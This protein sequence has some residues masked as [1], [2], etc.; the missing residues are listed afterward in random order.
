MSGSDMGSHMENSAKSRKLKEYYARNGRIFIVI[1][2]TRNDV[3]APKHLLGDPAL[4]LVLNVR[5]PQ[6]IYFHHDYLESNF[7]FS[8][9]SVACH[10]PM[11]AIWAAYLPNKESEGGI[12]WEEDIPESVQ[13]VLKSV[14]NQQEIDSQSNQPVSIDKAKPID[15]EKAAPKKGKSYLRIVK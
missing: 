8:G 7:S 14:R 13:I 12:L 2:A 15:T 1:D 3:K 11:Q 10:I 4:K 5:M 6:P 9:R